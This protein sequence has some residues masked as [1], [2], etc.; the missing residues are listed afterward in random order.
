MDPT[1]CTV[2]CGISVVLDVIK[3]VMVN[4]CS[5]SVN[6]DFAGRKLFLNVFSLVMIIRLLLFDVSLIFKLFVE[7]YYTNK[8]FRNDMFCCEIFFKCNPWKE[9][10][11][12]N[13]EFIN[14]PYINLYVIAL[15]APILITKFDFLNHDR[16]EES[17]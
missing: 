8:W 12:F 11:H 14:I 4:I 15:N 3:C 17:R 1:L 7:S 6:T 2:F 13:S 9:R 16:I 5:K 10:F